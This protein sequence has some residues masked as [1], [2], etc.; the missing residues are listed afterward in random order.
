M[1][2]PTSNL[3]GVDPEMTS[4]GTTETVF[5]AIEALVFF[6]NVVLMG[7]ALWNRNYPPLKIKQI[8]VVVGAGC[9]NLTPSHTTTTTTTC[10]HPAIPPPH[11]DLFVHPIATLSFPFVD[12]DL[13]HTPPSPNLSSSPLPSTSSLLPS[14]SHPP[15]LFLP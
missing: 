15:L 3:T 11:F 13:D 8:Y 4:M 12:R 10:F 2:I 5:V 7:Y 9:G 14:P 6:L 1:P